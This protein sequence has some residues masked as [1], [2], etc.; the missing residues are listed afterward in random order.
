MVA[1][2]AIRALSRPVLNRLRQNFPKVK[3][4]F[5]LFPRFGVSPSN[6]NYQAIVNQLRRPGSFVLTGERRGEKLFGSAVGKEEDLI[7]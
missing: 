6:P 7:N 3:F 4:D 1:A 5:D 2:S